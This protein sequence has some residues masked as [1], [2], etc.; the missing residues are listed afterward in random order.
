MIEMSNARRGSP[1]NEIYLPSHSTLIT[2]HTPPERHDNLQSWTCRFLPVMPPTLERDKPEVVPTHGPATTSYVDILLDSPNVGSSTLS[3]DDVSKQEEQFSAIPHDSAERML[4]AYN[5]AIV[6]WYLFRRNSDNP[7]HLTKAI[8]YIKEARSLTDSENFALGSLGGKL[9][10]AS[11]IISLSHFVQ[12]QDQAKLVIGTAIWSVYQA[13]EEQPDS[14]TKHMIL[15][16][17][18]FMLKLRRFLL[19][20]D[21]EDQA[22]ALDLDHLDLLTRNRFGGV[23]TSMDDPYSDGASSQSH[24]HFSESRLMASLDIIEAQVPTFHTDSSFLE[25]AF[26]WTNELQWWFLRTGEAVFLNRAIS[27]ARAMHTST[28][29]KGGDTSVVLAKQLKSRFWHTGDLVALNEAIDL[30]RLALDLR[31]ASEHPHR[32]AACANLALSLVELFY[33]TGGDE[34]V[35]EAIELTNEALALRPR[36]HSG[37]PSACMALAV[38]LRARAGSTGNSDV[39]AEAMSASQEAFE[40]CPPGH[41]QHAFACAY[42]S[43]SILGYYN[44]CV[45]KDER[46]LAL[47]EDVAQEALREGKD[48]RSWKLL[49]TLSQL[50]VLRGASDIDVVKAIDHLRLSVR[51]EA[52]D[53]YQ[54]L[55]SLMRI[56]DSIWARTPG[57]SVLRALMPVYRS[58]IDLLPLL[59]GFTLDRPA[60]LQ[61]LSKGAKLG[62]EAFSCA[63]AIGDFRSGLEMLEHARGVMWAQALRLSKPSLQD[64]PGALA[65]ELTALLRDMWDERAS[66]L[67]TSSTGDHDRRHEADT[68]LQSL[69]AEV[70]AMPGMERFMLGDSYNELVAVSVHHP[71][72]VLAQGRQNSFALIIRS[73]HEP[74]EA[75]PLHCKLVEHD[76]AASTDG[77]VRWRG[78]GAESTSEGRGIKIVQPRSATEQMLAHLWVEIVHPVINHL[79]LQVRRRR[80]IVVML[81]THRLQ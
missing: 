52:Q 29:L 47:G 11:Y 32:D 41:P 45:V 72:V 19:R 76:W 81:A 73:P 24:E 54:L 3:D 25:I 61:A 58:A 31:L 51:P 16:M 23:T 37:R 66:D 63:A 67:H 1:W 5:L 17:G 64:L 60:Q 80:I 65:P 42:H 43:R 6:H 35:N 55:D 70:R 34:H 39:W 40:L 62:V 78:V 44:A 75:L 13:L 57:E 33:R 53:P 59:A 71:V 12:Q 14:S 10:A 49:T 79:K 8:D 38:A 21:L 7:L 69:L 4:P 30:E 20:M 18:F 27:L 9:Y 48:M 68:R 46:I 77:M 56:S 2:S 26:N 28:D 74:M 50:Q 15:K 22:H 36:P